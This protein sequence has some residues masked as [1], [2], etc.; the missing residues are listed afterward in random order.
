MAHNACFSPF[1]QFPMGENQVSIYIFYFF[2][3]QFQSEIIQM[4]SFSQMWMCQASQTNN[5]EG[6]KELFIQTSVSLLSFHIKLV[7]VK[8]F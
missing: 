8:V 3:P 7:H 1:N 2:L 6:T 5:V 4:N